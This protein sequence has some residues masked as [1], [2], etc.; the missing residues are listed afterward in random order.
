MAACA[1]EENA[2]HV[3]T[4]VELVEYVFAVRRDAVLKIQ[5]LGRRRSGLTMARA[6]V[7]KCYE[8]MYDAS[9]GSYYYFNSKTGESQWTKP[10]LLGS[11]VLKDT[12]LQKSAPRAPEEVTASAEDGA[13]ALWWQT[14]HMFDN[15]DTM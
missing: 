15:G 5:G 1:V 11:S 12:V 14:K 7:S 10:K 8:K 4:P 3:S 2:Q 13:A 6:V 9:T